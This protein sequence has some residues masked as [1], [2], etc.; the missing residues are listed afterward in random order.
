MCWSAAVSKSPPGILSCCETP[1]L[2]RGSGSR[3]FVLAKGS[4]NWI[5]SGVTYPFK[6]RPGVIVSDSSAHT[7]PTSL[8]RSLPALDRLIY[9]YH[10]RRSV[11]FCLISVSPRGLLHRRVPPAPPLQHP[12][13]I[14]CHRHRSKA[15]SLPGARKKKVISACQTPNDGTPPRRLGA[16][17]DPLSQSLVCRSSSTFGD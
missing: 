9:F 10:F 3:A 13:L 15:A 4:R 17:T 5:S 8:S 7:L 2:S 11:C 1:E 14:S 16:R 12:S 6:T